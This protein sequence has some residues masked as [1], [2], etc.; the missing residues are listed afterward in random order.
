M[1]FGMRSIAAAVGLVAGLA[2]IGIQAPAQAAPA[3]PKISMTAH[4]VA[5]PSAGAATKALGSPGAR[6]HSIA[7]PAIPKPSTSPSITPIVVFFPSANTCSSGFLCAYVP[8][9]PN[10]D[11]WEFKFFHCQRYSL[12]NF[13]DDGFDDSLAIDDQTGGVTT[14]YF[15]QSGNVRQTMK[16]AAGRLQHVLPGT[17]GW[18]P[19]FSIQV[20]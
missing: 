14:T 19:I 5:A 4:P 9:A 17:G 20:C 1:T 15:G 11:W 3:V 8:T 12:S 13:F 16:P 7:A 6:V 2:A 10:G 18:D